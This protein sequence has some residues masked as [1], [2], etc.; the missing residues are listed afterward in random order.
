MKEVTVLGVLHNFHASVFK[1]IFSLG[2]L[3]AILRDWRPECV[4]AELTPD[5]QTRH[6]ADTLPDFKMEYRE[7]ILPLAD[8]VGYTVVPVDYASSAYA[9]ECAAL[10]KVR[11]N[12]VPY[13]EAKHEL[14]TEFEESVFAALPRVFRS[15]QAINSRACD[16]LICALKETEQLWFFQDD[17]EKDIWERHN[18]LNYEHILKAIRERKEK[19]FLITFGLYHKYWFEQQLQQE[20]WLRFEPAEGRLAAL[21]AHREDFG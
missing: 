10:D 20:R 19:R 11:P 8:E 16:D 5:W 3:A 7:V 12:L 2:D 15:P 14:L 1:D 17:P 13:G 4:L 21:G 9:A 18:Q 6:T